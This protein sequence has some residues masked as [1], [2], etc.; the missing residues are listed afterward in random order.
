MGARVVAVANLKGGCGKTATAVNLADMLADAG[1]RILLIDASPQANATGYL[2]IDSREQERNLYE[3]LY[4]GGRIEDYILDVFPGLSLIPSVMDLSA[5]NM[6]FSEGGKAHDSDL[7]KMIEPILNDY[8]HIIFDCAPDFGLYTRCAL[9]AADFYL[10]PTQAEYLSYQGII[11]FREFSERAGGRI[12]DN[13][14]RSR[15]LLTMYSRNI[16]MTRE[17]ERR[18]TEE[19]HCELFN[20]RIRR[21]VRASEAPSYSQTLRMLAPTAGVTMDYREFAREYKEYANT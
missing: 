3:L 8:D 5:A 16:R 12:K 20:T 13:L 1:E 18:M 9:Y 21:G 11:T 6:F 10:F 2:G 17:M 15:I 19:F 4:E 14:R 7:R